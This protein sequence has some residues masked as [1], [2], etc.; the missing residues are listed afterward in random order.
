VSSALIGRTLGKYEIIELLGQ[1][2]MA[3]VYKGYHREIDRYIAV[4][5]LP[6]HPGR[7]PQFVDR[8]RLEAR[9]IARLQHPH[10]LS[11]YD[12]GTEDD[13]LYL[14]MAYVEGGSLSEL[15][16]AGELPIAQIEK[17]LREIGA[18]LAY[19]HRHG[20]IHRD[21]KPGNILLDSEGHA[22]LADF[23]IAKLTG[24]NATLT[25][26]GG[27]V[28]TP[29]YMAPEQSQEETVDH[30][31]DI[32]SLGVVV[33][34]M[35]AGRQ[36][37]FSANPLR[38]IMK[39]INDPIPSI[40]NMRPDLPPG[41]EAVMQTVM[42]KTS[43]ARYQTVTDFCEA[44][45]QAIHGVT[46][47][48]Q[49]PL[50]LRPGTETALNP[51]PPTNILN[52]P[53]V[54]SSTIIFVPEQVRSHPDGIYTF[55]FTDIEGSTQLWE[56]Q[57]Q[58]MSTALAYHDA[59]MAQ[60]I[61]T[62]R[63]KIFKT[64]GDGVYAVFD[65]AAYALQAAMT[66]QQ[67]LFQVST[68]TDAPLLPLT[69]RMVLYTGPAEERANDYF[70]PTL[71][72]AARLVKAAH[73][74]Q[75]LISATTKDQLS[76]DI[77][78]RDL[79][80]H[81]LHDTSEPEHIFQAQSP[82]FPLN[83]KPIRS[84]IPRPTNIPAPLT[85]FVGREQNLAEV[86]HLL[87][88][89][90]V[91]LLALL[92][93]GGIGKTRLSIQVGTALLDEYEDGVF[94]IPLAPLNQTEAI[95][96][97]IAQALNIQEDASTT[98]LRA[99]TTHL[100]SRQML[101]IFD[102]FEHLL[103]AAPLLNE[104]LAAA[105]RLKILVTS[106]EALFIYGERTYTV[107]PLNLPELRDDLNH[108]LQST[109]V[110]LFVERIQAMQP[111][112]TLS[113]ANTSD[114][115]KI[116]RHLEGLPLALELA[117]ARVRDL[118]LQ[119][120]AE[121]LTQRLALLNKGPRDL[122]MRQQTMRGAIEW[123]YQLL[124]ATEQQF[125][126][127]LAVFEGQFFAEAAQTVTDIPDLD[128]FKNKSLIQKSDAQVFSML[129]VLREYAMERLIAGDELTTLRQKHSS[130]YCHWLE[131]AEDH[132][133]GRDQIEWYNRVK[134]E[135]YNLQ[136]AL[137]WFLQQVDVENAGRMV[138]VLWRYWATQSLLS[139]GGHW[140]N[141]VL[142]H[143]DQ[144]SSLVH[145]RVTQG[146]GR[147]ALLR[148][149]YA[150][151]AAFQQ[152]SLALYKSI[153]HLPGQAAV[154]LS[155][156]EMDY[157]Q[158][159]HIQ[160]ENHL[161]ESLSLYRTVDNQAGIGRCLNMMGKIVTQNGEFTKAEPL[162]YESLALARE[163]G[164]S[165]SIALALYTLAG[166][167]RAQEKYREAEGYYR[168]SLAL[169]RE[170]NLAVGVATMLYNLGFTLQ[171]LGYHALAMQHFLEALKLLETLD[172]PMALAECLI[173]MAGAFLHQDKHDLCI[174]MLSAA[175]AILTPL[176]AQGQIDYVD[177]AQYDRIYAAAQLDEAQRQAAWSAGQSTPMEQIIREIFLIAG[178]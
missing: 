135:Q 55:L 104:L 7:D 64:V 77:E 85:S 70:G 48:T 81:Y 141:Q 16:A 45:S 27:V 132:L 143:A 95:I 52:T 79:G 103:E 51:E 34:E 92:G 152:T 73:G 41:L 58:A 46:S 80:R 159:N 50:E 22:L 12:Y 151:A 156:G 115:V 125:F 88:Q 57:P 38:M 42:A 127:R 33:Y 69:V 129:A 111:E 5:V 14:A 166:V 44:F 175:N 110:I 10:I 76:P 147:L 67:L 168:E 32:Y 65:A 26:P 150:Q 133:N 25:G 30:R 91:R 136:A 149:D 86:S 144:L 137:E 105:A 122:P 148:H 113:E 83:S 121:Q 171:G 165:E 15:I 66:I 130:Y 155:L 87:R 4:K 24:T 93:P 18:A 177:Q 1:G 37:Y 61:E 68:R 120:I 153:N 161:G 101:L 167:L 146:A 13:I 47:H 145:A 63:G 78:V 106:R 116:C 74:R 160:A 35:L 39:H 72:R 174:Q 119:E 178:Q 162:L 36:P 8:F 134:V 29:A 59:V 170:L 138:A 84:R 11:L 157:V 163:H 20:V 128:D 112:F 107:L 17:L 176:N 96:K 82:H 97:F 49:S 172:E 23:G 3:T 60:T 118:T 117:A 90:N 71:N 31:A 75:I 99:V 108:L 94:F 173:G 140:I 6:P 21:I 169:Y 131:V 89:T 164:S 158:G 2:G 142:A 126:A 62:Y 98:L 154:L 123:S 114:V 102:N 40:T 54:A 109:S 139:E 53:A 9:T 43:A 100:Q 28:G 124:S 19:A 56:Q